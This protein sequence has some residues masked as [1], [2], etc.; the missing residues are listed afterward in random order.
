M[1]HRI[2]SIGIFLTCAITA[3]QSSPAAEPSPSSEE[4]K[5]NALW[6]ESLSTAGDFGFWLYPIRGRCPHL[7][8]GPLP[9]V[10]GVTGLKA[11]YTVAEMH[12][13]YQLAPPN[14]YIGSKCFDGYVELSQAAEKKRYKGKY[15]FLMS[16]GNL[17]EGTFDAEF[18]R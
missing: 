3:T 6:N 16:D 10:F 17:R 18:C 12:Y 9:L 8:A 2:A 11:R 4:G 5:V 15:R 14:Q 7:R 13:C 1:S